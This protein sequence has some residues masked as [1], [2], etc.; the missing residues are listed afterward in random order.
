MANK[1]KEKLSQNLNFERKKRKKPI[2][3]MDPNHYSKERFNDALRHVSSN[4]VLGNI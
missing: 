2:Y 3:E 4:N 1:I